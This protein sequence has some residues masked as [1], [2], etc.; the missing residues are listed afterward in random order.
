MAGFLRKFATNRKNADV[1]HPAPSKP[2]VLD[3]P[4]S[5]PPLFARFATTTLAEPESSLLESYIMPV[6]KV[7]QVEDEWD[8][9]KAL[10]EDVPP[11]PPPAPEPSPE[12]PRETTRESRV[13]PLPL[14]RRKYTGP[15]LPPQVKVAG[16]DAPPPHPIRAVST[17][18]DPNNQHSTPISHHPSP[19]TP[20][21]LS[22]DNQARSYPPQASQTQNPVK[23]KPGSSSSS[24]SN[25]TDATRFGSSSSAFTSTSSIAPA[26]KVR[27]T[28]CS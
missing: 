26:I 18:Q 15:G 27:F 20:P 2:V 12:A 4:P 19:I 17:R 1:E 16:P 10:I 21:S 14:T 3:V 13:Q 28:F 11:P 9:W 7:Q 5:L 8:P 23:Q 24:S 25:H 22:Q 6:A